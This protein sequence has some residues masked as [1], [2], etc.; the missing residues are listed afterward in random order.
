MNDALTVER[1]ALVRLLAEMPSS[2]WRLFDLFSALASHPFAASDLSL[3]RSDGAVVDVR[4]FG[5]TLVHYHVD[6]AAKTVIILD[7]E[8]VTAD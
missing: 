4:V 2:Q 5:D 6:H 1:A 7:Y 3:R 8:V